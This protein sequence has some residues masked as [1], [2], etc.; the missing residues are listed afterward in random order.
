MLNNNIMCINPNG[1]KFKEF[2]KF[3]NLKNLTY[4][5]VVDKTMLKKMDKIINEIE[6]EYFKT[7]Y[8]NFKA[9]YNDKK[10]LKVKYFNNPIGRRKINKVICSTSMIR[11]LR[12]IL[13]SNVYDDIDMKNSQVAIFLNLI[14]NLGYNLNDFPTLN[15]CYTNKDYFNRGIDVI[16]KGGKKKK[17]QPFHILIDKAICFFNT[18]IDIHFEFSLNLRKK[19]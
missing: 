17:K 16:L 6:D 5:E 11:E 18:E 7:D 10:G 14:Q 19:K 9:N 1:E 4:T 13:Y 15:K 2:Y 12:N 8:Y 3:H